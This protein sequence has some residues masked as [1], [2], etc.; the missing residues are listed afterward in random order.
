VVDRFFPKDRIQA[1]IDAVLAL[2][3][4]SSVRYIERLLGGRRDGL[5]VAIDLAWPGLIRLAPV[6]KWTRDRTFVRS[7]PSR[8]AGVT[9]PNIRSPELVIQTVPGA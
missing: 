9:L 4:G 6:R 7:R 8:A 1:G 2:P 5:D 3:N